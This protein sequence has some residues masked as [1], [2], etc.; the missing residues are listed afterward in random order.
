[1][2]KVEGVLIAP[3][4]QAW[5][6]EQNMG[7]TPSPPH[8]GSG[9]ICSSGSVRS[10]CKLLWLCLKSGHPST[11]RHRWQT[12]FESTGHLLA[13]PSVSAL[14]WTDLWGSSVGTHVQTKCSSIS[15]YRPP[16][17]MV[18]DLYVIHEVHPWPCLPN[19]RSAAHYT[20]ECCMGLQAQ[21]QIPLP[22]Q[23]GPPLIPV[24]VLCFREGTVELFLDCK[25]YFP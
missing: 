12:S 23:P 22:S 11:S 24:N 18:Q 16:H 6:Q 3:Q 8:A 19:H 20:P 1:M 2:L 21:P 9:W 10:V 17:P 4:N 5:C 14:Q 15:L 7:W 13:L 25:T